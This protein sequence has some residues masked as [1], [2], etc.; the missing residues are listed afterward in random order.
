[1]NSCPRCG[2]NFIEHEIDRFGR[3]WLC[4]QCGWSDNGFGLRGVPKW[5][6]ATPEILAQ[7]IEA[8]TPTR[9]AS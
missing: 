5:T 2:S 8:E 6:T 1:M 3:Y 7:D 4:H 9:R